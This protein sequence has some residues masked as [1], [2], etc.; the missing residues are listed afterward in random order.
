MKFSALLFLLL[1]M[2][3]G[4]RDPFLPAGA[5]RCPAGNAVSVPWRLQGIIG[6][7]DRFEGWLISLSGK[8]LHVSVNDW[9]AGA[10]WQVK[11]IDL[12]GITLTDEQ[13]CQPPQTLTFKGEHLVKENRVGADSG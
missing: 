13:A 10:G 2:D 3:V 9:P 11:H 6:R 5:E 7:P 4:A 1:A 12:R 8:R